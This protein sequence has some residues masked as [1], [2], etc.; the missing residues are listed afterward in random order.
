[1]GDNPESAFARWARMKRARTAAS[2]PVA[3]DPVDAGSDGAAGSSASAAPPVAPGSDES[4]AHSDRTA[5]PDLPDIESLTKD[6]DFTVFMREGVPEDIRRLALRRLW[7]SDPV[8][9]NLDGLRD[10]GEDYSQV[11]TVAAEIGTIYRAGAG[12]LADAAD[13]RAAD[14]D[15]G[16]KAEVGDAGVA[17]DGAETRPEAADSGADE[18]RHGDETGPQDRT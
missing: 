3:A 7:R 16:T 9:A 14:D 12:Y 2:A 18:A 6:S 15:A 1:M 17:G 10:Y 11:G 8:F 13:A 4:A 5:P